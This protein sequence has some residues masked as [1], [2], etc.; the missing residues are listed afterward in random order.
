[1]RKQGLLA[2]K[3]TFEQSGVEFIDVSGVRLISRSPDDGSEIQASASPHMAPL[4]GNTF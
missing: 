1:M 4:V 2:V 3:L